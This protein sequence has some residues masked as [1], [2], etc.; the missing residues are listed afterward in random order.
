VSLEQF[1]GEGVLPALDPG[2]GEDSGE[3]E[4]KDEGSGDKEEEHSGEG[5]RGEAEGEGSL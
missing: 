4:D 3:S 1:Q 5:D 2:S